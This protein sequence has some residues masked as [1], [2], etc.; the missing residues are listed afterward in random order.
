MTDSELSLVSTDTRGT[1]LS[2]ATRSMAVSTGFRGAVVNT[3][4]RGAAVSTGPHGVVVITS[5]GGTV[6]VGDEGLAAVTAENF[7]WRVLVGAV[8]CQRTAAGVFVLR[9]EDFPED[10]GRTIRI[11]DGRKW[12]KPNPFTRVSSCV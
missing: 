7:F 8:V 1:A 6:T 5:E 9:A 2:V 12:A 11:Q 3:G 10:I 4:F